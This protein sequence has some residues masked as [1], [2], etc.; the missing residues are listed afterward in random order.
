VF[1]EEVLGGEM[2][3]SDIG[4]RTVVPLVGVVAEIFHAVV[5]FGGYVDTEQ[6]VLQLTLFVYRL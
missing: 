4:V 2:G 5:V 1:I 6:F 3:E